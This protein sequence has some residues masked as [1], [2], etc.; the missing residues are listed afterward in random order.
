MA[1]QKLSAAHEADTKLWERKALDEKN[2]NISEINT[3]GD[4]NRRDYGHDLIDPTLPQT[5]LTPYHLLSGAKKTDTIVAE[6]LRACARVTRGR[7]VN[8]SREELGI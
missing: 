3:S 5:N 1:A 2:K 4:S 6:L 8:V 7:G